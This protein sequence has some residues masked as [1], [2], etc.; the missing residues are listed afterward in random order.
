MKRTLSLA[1][2]FGIGMLFLMKSSFANKIDAAGNYLRHPGITAVASVGQNNADLWRSI[3]EGLRNSPII[4]EYYSLLPLD[5]YHMTTTDIDTES[6][7]RGYWTGFITQYLPFFRDLGAAIQARAFQPKITLRNP[8]VSGVIMLILDLDNE[9]KQQVRSVA[10]TFG[11]DHKIPWEFHITL[12]YGF[13]P[14]PAEAQPLIHQEV[15]RI[16]N[17]A[18]AY[19]RPI[20]LEE[21]KL[22]YFWDMT[23]FIPWTAETNPFLP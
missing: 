11:L 18:K 8:L 22:C 2:V 16:F 19:Q 3:Y 6:Q 20:V 14:I 7:R 17:A 9:Q 21:P 15:Q 4:T 13:K 23:R 1:T 12:A 5:S 10:E